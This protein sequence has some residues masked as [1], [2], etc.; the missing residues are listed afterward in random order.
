VTPCSDVIGYERFRGTWKQTVARSEL[1]LPYYVINIAALKPDLLRHFGACM[2]SAAYRYITPTEHDKP[3]FGVEHS[4]MPLPSVC[5]TIDIFKSRNLLLDR[6]SW[7]YVRHALLYGFVK[8]L[9][10][11]NI[12]Y[13]SRMHCLIKR[14]AMKMYW[15]SEGIEIRILNSGTR[16]RGA[17]SFIRNNYRL[18][19][20][21]DDDLSFNDIAGRHFSELFPVTIIVN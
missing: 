1:L 6:I 10:Q 8:Y 20:N 19:A 7:K 3:V 14:D 9:T 12:L 5:S 4:G 18:T 16:R 2:F 21:K 17:V 11:K 13:L 15:G